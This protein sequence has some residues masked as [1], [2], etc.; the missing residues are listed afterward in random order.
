MTGNQEGQ[1]Q[2]NHDGEE[3]ACSSKKKKLECL[4]N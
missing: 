2:A 4:S 3:A 1:P